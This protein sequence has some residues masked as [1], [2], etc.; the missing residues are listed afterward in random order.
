MV[1]LDAAALSAQPQAGALCAAT[2]LRPGLPERRFAT[3]LQV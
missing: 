2:G 3:A 1:G